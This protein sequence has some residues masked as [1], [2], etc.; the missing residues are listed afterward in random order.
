MEEVVNKIICCDVLEGLKKIPDGIVSLIVSSPP[1]NVG[2]NYTNNN[3]NLTYENYLFWLKGIFI[4]CKRVLKTGGRMAINIDA[5]ASDERDKE[6]SRCIYAHLYNMMKEIGMLFRTEICWYKQN[7]S[8]NATC[9][10]SYL[11][12]SSP[13]IRR[14]HEYILIFSKDSWRL[15]GNN[16]L[17][18]M[19]KEEF[20]Q[21]TLSTWIIQPE[22]KK[23]GDHPATFPEELAKR[24]IKLFSYR[25]DIVLDMF[26]GSGTTPYMARKLGRKYIGIDNSKEYCDFA[27]QRIKTLDDIVFDEKYIPRSERFK[28]NKQRVKEGLPPIKRLSR[29]EKKKLKIDSKK[30]GLFNV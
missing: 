26:S 7:A 16:E 24:L 4:E 9:W 11:S 10:G 5:M 25:E 22:R 13:T 19:T 17:S 14:N 29:S 30:E 18:D 8:G 28:T 1:Y 3:D 20:E 2:K 6:Y 12:C 15:E 21:Y 23:N 27:E